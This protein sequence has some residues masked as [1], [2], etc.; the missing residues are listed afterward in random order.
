MKS[1]LN[2]KFNFFLSVIVSVIFLIFL[3]GLV[4][5]NVE[6]VEV[7]GATQTIK[8]GKTATI[9]FKL[10]ETGNGDVNLTINAPTLT[11][12]SNQLSGSIS[13]TSISLLN[14][15][16]SGLIT[17]TY[18]VPI[19][20][21]PGVYTG[22]ITLSNTSSYTG[23]ISNQTVTLTVTENHPSEILRCKTLGNPGDLRIRKI[24]FSNNGLQYSTF[25]EDE[26]W[27]PFENIEANIR[28]KNNGN[29]NIDD[30][31]LSWGL[32]DLRNSQWVIE[33]DEIDNFKLKDGDEKTFTVKFKIDDRMDV[34]LEDLR[35]GK[36]YRFYV[37]AEG[38]VDNSSSPKTCAFDSRDVS[39]V[40]ESDFV[41]LDNFQIPEKVQCGQTVSV[42]VNVLNVGDRDQD[43]VSVRV[44]N[45]ENVLNLNRVLEV[46][47]IDAF[48]KIPLSFTFNIPES[49]EE[50]FYALVFEVY[51]EDNNIYESD[52]DDDPSSFVVPIK[53]EGNCGVE[54]RVLI[55]ASFES[56]AVAG[57]DLV[58]KV[59]FLNTGKSLETLKI[60]VT[61]F[62]E[63]ANSLSVDRDSLVLGAG[64]SQDV[65]LT[66]KVKNTASGTYTFFI[67]GVNSLGQ[68]ITQPISVTIGGRKAGI[69]GALL[70][71]SGWFTW[72]IGI[73]NVILIIIIIIVAVR[74]TRK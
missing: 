4:A 8:E 28:I 46:G 58:I 69:T 14:G 65:L 21:A 1:K 72:A 59:S 63:F 44:F 40:I 10:S 50:K 18:S 42:S 73:L 6:F 41:V 33:P 15:T 16:K 67:R 5:A 24:D 55:S 64:Q 74:L 27:F 20:Q 17:L 38:V 62:E 34:D 47:D 19:G 3:T 56:E 26:K 30:I 45:R 35:E 71:E 37:F 48:D 43:D 54:K 39:I 68:E 22:I 53:V 31:E 7:N 11:N 32:W 52:F 23:N 9:T 51:D 2:N 12:N 29:E 25:G 36:N 57:K 70:G 66:F 60:N 13:S 61:G 49:I